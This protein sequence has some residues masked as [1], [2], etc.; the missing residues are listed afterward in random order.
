MCHAQLYIVYVNIVYIADI[1]IGI[2]KNCERCPIYI[3]ETIKLS[4]LATTGNWPPKY[5]YILCI[6]EY[7]S[8]LYSVNIGVY[9]LYYVK[10][11]YA[12]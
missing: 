5:E 9:I 10:V 11:L 4:V 3:F 8:Q 6:Y 2:R 7:I 1:C 12:I